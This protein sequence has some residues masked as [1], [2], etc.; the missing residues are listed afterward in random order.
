MN[1]YQTA[2][3]VLIILSVVFVAVI[4]YVLRWFRQK[5]V[6]FFQYLEHA[7][8]YPGLYGAVSKEGE[9]NEVDAKD[10]GEWHGEEG[11]NY[12]QRIRNEK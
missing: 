4:L 6:P 9:N 8:E 7:E 10:D 11:K 3:I 12:R 5:V 1:L 2:T